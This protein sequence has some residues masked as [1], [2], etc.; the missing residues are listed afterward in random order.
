MKLSISS[1]A[2]KDPLVWWHKYEGR[3]SNVAF[4]TKQILGISRSQIETKGVF[5]LIGVLTTLR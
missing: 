3:F 2:Y 4:L 5:S 1:S